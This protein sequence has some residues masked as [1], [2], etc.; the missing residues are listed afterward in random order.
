MAAV[1][2]CENI[3]LGSFCDVTENGKKPIG[4]DKEEKNRALYGH[5]SLIFLYISLPPLHNFDVK[6]YSFTF[7]GGHEHKA[8]TKTLFYFS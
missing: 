8:M 4:L 1:T 2:S 6:M 7:C 3:L 5:H